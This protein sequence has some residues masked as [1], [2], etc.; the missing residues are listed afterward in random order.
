ML[1]CH[2][3]TSHWGRRRRRSMQVDSRVAR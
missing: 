3:V 1:L 2:R